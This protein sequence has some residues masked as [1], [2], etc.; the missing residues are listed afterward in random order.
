MHAR[1]CPS[2]VVWRLL[3]L[4]PPVIITSI[5]I[6]VLSTAH[7]HIRAGQ[8]TAHPTATA[9]PYPYAV[10]AALMRCDVPRPEVSPRCG[11]SRGRDT[12]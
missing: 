3:S 11:Q 12:R 7:A 9:Y 2:R 4:V 10:R 1:P 8:N 5:P 6:G